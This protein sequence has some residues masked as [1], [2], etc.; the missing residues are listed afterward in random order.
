MS[1]PDQ[2]YIAAVV[3]LAHRIRRETVPFPPDCWSARTRASALA[4]DR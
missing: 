1:T 3:G 2:F 4:V